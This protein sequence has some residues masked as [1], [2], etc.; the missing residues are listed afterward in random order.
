MAVAAR[1]DRLKQNF[2]GFTTDGASAVIGIGDTAIGCPPQGYIQHETETPHF[3]QTTLRGQLASTRRAQL[4]EED[5]VRRV[6]IERLM[7][8]LHVDLSEIG[9]A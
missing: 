4:R 2:H 6:I 3:R 1:N 8:T 9:I 7:F 5:L